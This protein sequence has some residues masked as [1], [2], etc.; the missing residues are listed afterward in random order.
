MKPG[1]VQ[2]KQIKVDERM[3]FLNIS[4]QIPFLYKEE[5]SVKD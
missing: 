1:L 2:K 4:T 3:L 5:K